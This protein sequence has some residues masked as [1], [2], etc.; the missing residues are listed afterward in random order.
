[1]NNIEEIF[2]KSGVILKGHFLL[3]SGLHSPV[4]WEKIPLYVFLILYYI[5]HGITLPIYPTMV[6]RYFGRKAFGS[7]QGSK[8]MFM[9]PFSIVAP[10]YGGWVYDTTGSYITAFTVLA[11]MVAAS[12]VILSLTSPQTA[13]PNHQYP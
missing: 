11:G 10:I 8:M 1:M 6:G 2:E 3:A 9:T 5:G 7:I 12:V 4:Y 13:S